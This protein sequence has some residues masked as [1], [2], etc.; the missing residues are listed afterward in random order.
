MSLIRTFNVHDSDSLV[1]SDIRDLLY[2]L[3]LQA[4]RERNAGEWPALQRFQRER[5]R[6]LKGDA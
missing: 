3:V 2:L 1:L 4:D 5:M 6:Y